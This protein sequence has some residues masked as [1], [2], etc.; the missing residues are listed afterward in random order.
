MTLSRRAAAT[1]LALYLLT[2]VFIVFW[3]NHEFS[4][5]S[6]DGMT[7]AAR[8]LGAR[9]RW[10]SRG[11]VGFGLNVLLFVPLSFLGSVLKPQWGWGR[12]ALA[13]LAAAATIELVQMLFLSGRMPSAGDVLANTMGAL[14][15]YAL[16][17][18][19]LRNRAAA[20]ERAS[21]D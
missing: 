5:P 21:D 17:A 12:W 15:G 8:D 16:A 18:L 2:L 20:A 11:A 19:L 10:V 7:R 3:P 1:V 6:I 9:P 13:G 4:T 14:V